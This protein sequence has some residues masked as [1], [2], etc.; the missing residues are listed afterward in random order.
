MANVINA[1]TFMFCSTAACWAAVTPGPSAASNLTSALM[2]I[3]ATK[4][5][6][7]ACALALKNQMQKST[8]SPL[9]RGI[10]TLSLAI[11]SQF[12]FFFL[13]PLV[14]LSLISFS[15]VIFSSLFFSFSFS[16]LHFSS[17]PYS[18]QLSL[19]SSLINFT[20]LL[21]CSC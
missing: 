2:F 19:L 1:A 4:P 8:S 7:K 10:G 5:N 13:T 18:L 3:A 17:L 9:N 14:F 12:L 11:S 20:L 21:Y 16:L 6:R 15:L